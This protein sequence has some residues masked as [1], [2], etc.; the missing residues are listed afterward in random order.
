MCANRRLHA[1]LACGLL[2]LAMLSAGGARAQPAS[3][4]AFE[5][6]DDFAGEPTAARERWSLYPPAWSMGD[7]VMRAES[8]GRTVISPKGAPLSG[9]QALGVT[10]VVRGITAKDWKVAGLTIAQDAANYW[11]LALVESPDAQGRRRFLE[12]QEM[13]GGTWLAQS[14]TEHKLPSTEMVGQDFVW[15]YDH[16]YRLRLALDAH[17]IYGSVSE[18]DGTLRWSAGYLF[19]VKAVTFGQGGLH[20]AGFVSEFDDYQMQAFSEVAPV[21]TKYPEYSGTADA[22]IRLE[23]TGF[24]HTAQ[25]EGVDWIVDPLGRAFIALG[26]DHCNYGVHWCEK[27]GYSPYNRNNVEKYGS[28]EKWAAHAT[29][30]LRAWNF[31]ALG[32]N[33]SPGTRYQGLA[34]TL[35][36]G[37]GSAFAAQDDLC[38]QVHWTG[39]PNIFS[40]DWEAFC[41][42]RA[43][44]DCAPSRDDPWL[45]GYF[46]DNELEWYGKIGREWGLFVEA[47][48]K[49]AQHSAK[50]A[51]V[52]FLRERYGTVDDFNRHWQPAVADWEALASVTE[53]PEPTDERAANDRLDFVR[54]CADRYFA[55]TTAAIRKHDPNHMILGNRFAGDAPLIWDLAG[56]YCDIV[57]V[58]TYPRLDLDQG[59]VLGLEENLRRWHEQCQRP[60]MITEWSFPALDS[61]LPCKHGAGMRVA[62]QEQKARCYEVF[63]RTIFRL[64]FIVGSDY[65]MWVDEPALGISSTF[66]EDSNYGLVNER[67]EAYEAL[68]QTATRVNPRMYDLHA[69][70]TAA[71]SVQESASGRLLVRNAGPL[72]ARLRLQ[73]WMHGEAS[74]REIELPPNGS[75]LVEPPSPAQPG[76]NLLICR[77]EIVGG[78][79]DPDDADNE[80]LRVWFEPLPQA[81][82]GR[83]LAVYN[84]SDRDLNSVPVVLRGEDLA[85]LGITEG[86]LSAWVVNRDG[87][88]WNVPSQLDELP[89]GKEFCFIVPNL[90][91]RSAVQVALRQAPPVPHESQM[92][93][94]SEGSRWWAGNDRLTL[95]KDEEDGALIDRVLLDGQEL[96]NFVA[97]MCQGQVG[98]LWVAADRFEGVRATAGMARVI[99]EVTASYSGREAP[100]D[101]AGN[102]AHA[103][104]ATYRFTLYPGQAWFSSRLLSI[105]N[106]DSAPLWAC[107]YYHYIRSRMGGDASDDLPGGAE[108]PNFYLPHGAWKDEKAGLLYGATAQPN[109]G[110]RVSFWID[111]A[112]NQHPD[113]DRDIRQTLAPG[114]SFTDP[115]PEAY[116]FSSYLAEDPTPW[117]TVQGVVRGW[118]KVRWEKR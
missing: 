34:H 67:D 23:A 62:T 74:Q 17:G 36:A 9:E 64:P 93:F 54:L 81:P 28:E 14:V 85:G 8:V 3:T 82:D 91:A 50:T 108:V 65:F 79:E 61:G 40:P 89:E 70:R 96:G 52:D 83:L 30:R 105:E 115:Q 68:T 7:G 57:S 24:F 58:N 98:N 100:V 102:P 16:P 75:W 86:P 4:P 77:A 1:V 101:E 99:L 15:E 32:A 42:Y 26:T 88:A 94:R 71:V 18:L 10:L 48:K 12:L 55:V 53:A 25:R 76:A 11:H 103:F 72:G 84:P 37:M 92:F 19:S 56:K 106:V 51:V 87:T 13:L 97:L 20:S 5:F 95:A 114:E 60:M 39:F 73:I 45:L 117:Q 66:P 112:G 107:S 46:I 21:A 110:Y 78:A 38:P 6:A 27:L 111:E 35:F 90:P 43:E 41:D 29:E 47:F 63:Q 80:G 33:N 2:L 104:R 44:Q 109:A 22:E 113:I 49:P 31:N 118:E 69:G 116:I 59:V